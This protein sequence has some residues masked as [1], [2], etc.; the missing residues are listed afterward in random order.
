MRN[1]RRKAA[2]HQLIRQ[3]NR[4]RDEFRPVP[5]LLYRGPADFVLKHGRWYEPV[6]YP[7]GFPSNPPRMCYGNSIVLAATRGLAYV[8]GFM[9]MPRILAV[10]P[11]RS[12]AVSLPVPSLAQAMAHAWNAGDQIVQCR[13]ERGTFLIDSTLDN[14]ALAYLGVEFSVERADECT[15]VGDAAVIDDHKRGWPLLR[16]PW[17]GEPEGLVWPLSER[18]EALRTGD[19]ERRQKLRSKLWAEVDGGDVDAP[20]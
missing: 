13:H 10:S 15:W 2:R 6:P 5:G 14:G 9:L 1:E 17:R 16:E 8:E 7:A 3:L 18:L 4:L 19:Q 20:T 12:R 11:D